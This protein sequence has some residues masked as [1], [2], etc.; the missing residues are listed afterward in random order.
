LITQRL[1]ARGGNGER[2]SR[3]S[4]IALVLLLLGDHRLCPSAV[5]DAEHEAGSKKVKFRFREFALVKLS[6]RERMVY[7]QL[8]LSQPMEL[9]GAGKH[10]RDRE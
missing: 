1:R 6:G 7:G 8:Q 2:R 3:A 10:I 4:D 9:G 5:D